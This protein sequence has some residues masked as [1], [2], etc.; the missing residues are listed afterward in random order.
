[1]NIFVLKRGAVIKSFLIGAAL[2]LSAG[3]AGAD[4]T[5]MANSST[6]S[7]TITNLSQNSAVAGGSDFV[8][9][10]NGSGFQSGAILSFE[11]SSKS[12]SFNSSTQLGVT[13]SKSDIKTPPV[14]Y[15]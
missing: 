14:E 11:E 2:V 8:L 3:V 15:G 9:T 12:T 10:V 1:M 4:T 6:P 13:I 5:L 7:P